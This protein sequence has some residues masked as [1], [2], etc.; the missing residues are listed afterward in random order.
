MAEKNEEFQQKLYQYQLLEAQSEALEEEL[1]KIVEEIR[2]LENSKQT[3]KELQDL[4]EKSEIALPLGSGSFA[5]G[6]L[7]NVKEVLINLGANVV[8]KKPIEEA[9]EVLEGRKE[10]IKDVRKTIKE[11]MKRVNQNLQNL[12]VELQKAQ[13]G[14]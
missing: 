13:K 12:S 9:V 5:F 1:E 10:E 4:K 8:V 3:L 7:N 2:E 11:N 14:R 6:S